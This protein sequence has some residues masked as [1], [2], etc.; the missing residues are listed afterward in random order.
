M[1]ITLTSQSWSIS[2]HRQVDYFEGLVQDCSNTSAFAMDLLQSYTNPSIWSS[3]ACLVYQHIKAL[4]YWPHVNGIYQW[5]KFPSQRASNAESIYMPCQW[6][7]TL[8][9]NVVFHIGW[10]QIQNDPRWLRIHTRISVLIK[11]AHPDLSHFVSR[12]NFTHSA[13]SN[14][15]Y[16]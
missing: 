4:N 1:D 11:A 3:T 13:N 8:R 10:M 9:C 6:E 14:T 5:I 2:H 7:T 15:Q 12:S 16:R